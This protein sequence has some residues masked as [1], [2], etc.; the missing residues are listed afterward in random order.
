MESISP[1]LAHHGQDR[2][3]RDEAR[4]AQ[5]G[6]PHGREEERPLQDCGVGADRLLQVLYGPGGGDGQAAQNEAVRQLV[7]P[8]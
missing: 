6:R 5:E 8:L 1:S 4:A 7:G 2:R 3:R